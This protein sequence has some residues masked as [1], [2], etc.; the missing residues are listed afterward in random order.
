MKKYLFIIIALSVALQACYSDKTTSDINNIS[1]IEIDFGKYN[2]ETI[3]IDKN[4]V[5]TIDP[6]IQQTNKDKSLNYEWEVDQKTYSDEKE[7]KYTGTHLGTFLVRFRAYNEDGSTYKVFKLRV[8]SPYE[9]GLLILSEDDSRNSSL[10]FIKRHPDKSIEDTSKDEIDTDA[11]KLN[12]EGKSLDKGAT[13][14]VKRGSQFFISSEETGSIAIIN[15]Q[16][17]EEEGKITAP[18][19]PDFKP[20]RLNIPDNAAVSSIVMTRSGKLFNLATKEHLVLMNTAFNNTVKLEPKT[21]FV[22]DLNFTM[23]YFWDQ[24]ASRL[25][26]IWYTNSSSKDELIGQELRTFFGANNKTYTLTKHPNS[27]NYVRTVFGPYIQVYFGVPL[28]I[29]EKETF[30]PD[31]PTPNKTSVTMLD[32]KLFKLLYVEGNNVYQWYYSGTNFSNPPLLTIDVAGDI[33]YLAKNNEGKELFVGVY[34]N[35]ASGKKG[36]VLI[37]NIETGK[38]IGQF[39]GISD[40]PVKLLYKN[41]K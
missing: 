7:F 16:T 21:H 41:K 12:N 30:T 38:K 19:F 1:E 36:S 31:G 37:Y 9:E 29:L 2:L 5:L 11:F 8:N 15:G 4:E 33:T 10:G 26:N 27:N 25:W 23:N 17:F 22:G 18:E 35:N 24:N 40:K 34:D 6:V 39:I 3:E 32:E 13:D 20:F 28:E 14:I